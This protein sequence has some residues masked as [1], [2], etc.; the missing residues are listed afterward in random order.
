MKLDSSVLNEQW[1]KIISKGQDFD[2]TDRWWHFDHHPGYGLRFVYN[3]NYIH[4]NR[5]IYDN[6]WHHVSIVYQRNPLFGQEKMRLFFDGVQVG[7]NNNDL[8]EV[9]DND[10]PLTL[11][12]SNINYE[13]GLEGSLDEVII[14]NI[15]IAN[16]QVI[17]LYEIKKG[18][19]VLSNDI[20]IDGDVLTSNLVESVSS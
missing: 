13:R 20:D 18:A 9:N 3:W 17:E 1:V 19:N 2:N 12:A 8:P 11:G 16:E 15:P 6:E 5:R 4:F 10:G 14:Y 7:S